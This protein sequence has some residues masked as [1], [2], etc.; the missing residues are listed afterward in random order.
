MN[1][2]YNERQLQLLHMLEREG[3]A[4]VSELKS[5]FGV[6]EMTIRRDLER[7]EQSGSVRRIFGGAIYLGRDITLK[8][9]A[10]MLLEEKI[11]IGKHAASLIRSGDSIFIDG[12]TTA[13]QIARHVPEGIGVT[14][15]TN[16][17]NVAHELSDKKITTI[18]TGGLIQEAT[19]TLVGP[20]AS[21]TLSGMAFNRA[22]LGATGVS[23][24]HGFSNSNIYEAEI[25]RTAIMQANETVV[26]LDHSKF[27][28]SELFSFAELKA[29]ARIVTDRGPDEE[30][31]QACLEAE[32]EI[33]VCP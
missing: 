13:Y 15:V 33:M 29:A 2:T 16:A 22:F 31:H 18:V 3:E 19:S 17:L 14:V 20:H 10:G 4:K 30:L 5:H 9:R 24:R 25:K 7:L 26:V 1:V 6:T 28:A 8:E 12:G 23:A 32:V 11:R 27:G 21:A